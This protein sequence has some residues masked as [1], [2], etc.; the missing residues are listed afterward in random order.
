MIKLAWKNINRNR[1]R[2]ILSGLAIFIA[3]IM[4]CLMLSLEYGMINGMR[5]NAI[6]HVAGNINIKTIKYFD[7]ERVNPIQ[8][9]IP[10]V[11]EKIEKINQIEGASAFSMTRIF[12]TIW[13]GEEKKEA[14]AIGTNFNN[15]KFFSEK[16]STIHEGRLPTE[17]KR[18]VAI[19]TKLAETLSLK[20]GDTFT[21]LTRTASGGSN[22]ISVKVTAIMSFNDSELNMNAFFIDN[23]IISKMLR[24]RDGAIEILVYTENDSI[25]VETIENVLKDD[26]LKYQTWKDLSLIGVMIEFIDI[27]YSYIKILFFLLASTVIINTTMMSVIE[28]RREAAT[29]IALGYK[30]K[31]VRNLFLLESG[32]ISFLASVFGC[33]VA[34]ILIITIGQKGIDIMNLGGDAVKGYNFNTYIYLFLPKKEYISSVIFASIIAIVACYFPTRKILKLQPAKALHDEI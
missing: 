30:E 13:M 26:S 3:T 1:K 33:L 4:V 14:F 17:G 23:K 20:T 7:N 25:T 12:T 22:A 9:Y 2:T 15:E 21:F 6:N 28:R 32:I 31:W 11:S 10:D 5:D 16:E 29:F 27:F 19:T 34:Y 24:M 18:E 8:F